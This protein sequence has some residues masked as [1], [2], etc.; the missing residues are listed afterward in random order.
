MINFFS[1]FYER[2]RLGED[3]NSKIYKFFSSSIDFVTLLLQI[4]PLLNASAKHL[5]FLDQ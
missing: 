1:V 2:S 5:F 3:L 4:F